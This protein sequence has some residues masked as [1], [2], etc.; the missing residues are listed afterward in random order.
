MP[1][2]LRPSRRRRP[3]LVQFTPFAGGWR[4]FGDA[5]R[6]ASDRTQ[7]AREEGGCGDGQ[8][9]DQYL[10]LVATVSRAVGIPRLT[11]TERWGFVGV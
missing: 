4:V 7:L 6:R 1:Q 9:R 2:R 11:R 8:S 3:L 10:G 5:P